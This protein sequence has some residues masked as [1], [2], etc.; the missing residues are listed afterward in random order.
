MQYKAFAN[1]TENSIQNFL[2]QKS[3]SQV[4]KSKS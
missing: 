1:I 4:Q 2:N 3:A